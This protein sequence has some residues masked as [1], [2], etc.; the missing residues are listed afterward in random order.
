MVAIGSLGDVEE[1]V[2]GV[3][4]V[5]AARVDDVV[6]DALAEGDARLEG[7]GDLGEEGWVDV[8]G[9]VWSDG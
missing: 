5:E 6:L 4:A 3:V 1:L 9:M 7:F 8:G 2:D